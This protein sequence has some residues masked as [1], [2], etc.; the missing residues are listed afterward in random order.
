ML[1]IRRLNMDSSWY[2][3]WDTTSVVLDPWLLGV[4]VDYLPF[5]NT[6]WHV[7]PPAKIDSIPNY[8]AIVV[9]QHFS[10][11]CHEETLNSMDHPLIL[12][13]GKGAKRINKS[14]KDVEL[15][16]I[17]NLA[18]NLAIKVGELEFSLLP[19][20]KRFKASFNGVVIKKGTH[21]IVYCPHGYSISP[22]QIKVLNELKIILLITSFSTFKLPFLL[23]GYVNP[24]I[25]QASKL[26]NI[27][28][29]RYIVA[30]HDEDKASSGLVKRIAK[31]FYPKV[32][33]LHNKFPE[34]FVDLKDT[35]EMYPLNY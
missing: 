6:Q 28:K 15:R 10:D 24:G 34:K 11:H 9:S 21:A 31:V 25:A 3:S 7:Y 35:E 12:T 29:P 8:D 23:G 14:I 16:V 18:A 13:T 1:Q 27:L 33:E 17:P 20:P 26:I 32:D 5:F 2:I 30:T 19:A 4:E 22:D